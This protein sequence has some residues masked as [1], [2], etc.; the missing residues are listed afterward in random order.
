MAI[1]SERL[2]E[3]VLIWPA[4]VATAMS[5][6]VASSVSPERWLMIALYLFALGHLH[7]VEGLGQGADLVDLHQDAVGDRLVDPLLEP[8]GV[9]DEQVVADELAGVADRPRS[10]AS[11]PPS[12][13]RSSR[14]RSR[15]SG[16]SWPS[17]R[18]SRPSGRGSSWAENRSRGCRSPSL[19]NS[20][21]ATSRARKT[22]APGLY[23]A[24]SM[25]VRMTSMASS[26]LLRLGAKP[27][28]SPTAVFR[29]LPFE[30]GLEVVEDLGAA[31]EGLGEALGPEGD[32]HELL[33]VDV[34]VGVRA[35]VEDVHQGDG[36]DPGVDAAEVAV[37]RQARG[38][39]G[40]LG[41]GEAD[42][43]DRVGAE[44]PLV[45]GAVERRSGRRRGPPGR[46]RR[47]RWRPW[48]AGR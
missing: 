3:P 44:L 4:L 34:V 21:E 43:E 25:A 14:P 36:Q 45:L 16:T 42:A 7:G 33:D 9:G 5:A 27:P 23:P 8:L 28:S 13:P 26:L 17:R 22:S 18:G 41:G 2:A 6:M 37:E 46:R 48:R 32:D 15:R 12:R 38:D 29:P 24:F 10:G 31:A 40:G 19:K 30:H 1:R 11:S 35:A 47:G 39:G 20:V